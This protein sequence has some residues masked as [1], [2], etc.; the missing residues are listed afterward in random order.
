MPHARAVRLSPEAAAVKAIAEGKM[1]REFGSYGK[2]NPPLL[3]YSTLPVLMA[4]PA[5]S[6]ML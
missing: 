1:E 6:V 4:T 5:R 2:K 3:R